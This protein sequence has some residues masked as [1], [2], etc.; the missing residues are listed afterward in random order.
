M[1]KQSRF[2]GGQSLIGMIIGIIGFIFLL[3]NL[4]IIHSRQILRF[5]PV[6]LVIFGV[7]KILQTNKTSGYIIGGSIAL[8]GCLMILHRLDIIY[9][10]FSDWWPLFMILVGISFVL[11]SWN[12]REML[13][14]SN[15]DPEKKLNLIAILG[16][17]NNKIDSAHFKGGEITA[18]M[19][20]VELDL[21]SASMQSEAKIS[22]FAI[23]GGIS[24]KV[25]TDWT[26]VLNGYPIM[27]GIEDRSVSPVDITKRLIIEGYAIMG[28][29]E[30]TN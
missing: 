24:I 4:N 5:W 11:K 13:E 20:G 29:V 7:M 30:I 27:G 1:L 12:K 21:R 14:S 16:G 8:I 22:V 25:P 23:W 19:G 18:I 6:I 17:T 2:P 15:I 26:V 3:D 10:R 28:G 9:F